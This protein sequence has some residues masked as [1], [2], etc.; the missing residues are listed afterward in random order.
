MSFALSSIVVLRAFVSHGSTLWVDFPAGR[1]EH[2]SL[3]GFLFLETSVGASPE[4]SELQLSF[5]ALYDPTHGHTT[6]TSLRHI[7]LNY[8]D[9]VFFS[10]M[11]GLNRSSRHRSWVPREQHRGRS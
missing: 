8:G 1:P 7:R 10:A 5:I 9:L 11:Y 6:P 3:D 4:A 2:V